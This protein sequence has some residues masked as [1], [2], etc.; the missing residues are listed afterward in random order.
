MLN[1][2]NKERLR[3]FVLKELKENAD[4]FDLESE[5][6]NSLTY[7]ENKNII[8]EKIGLF[9]EKNPLEDVNRDKIKQFER[10]QSNLISSS[11]MDEVLIKN[12]FKDCRIVSLAGLKN[13]GKTNNLVYLIK[14]LRE[15]NK[16]IPIYVF[17]MPIQVMN[18]LTRFNIKEISSLKHLIRKKNCLLII[19][20]FQKL[21]LNDRRYKDDLDDFIDFVYHNNVY[22]L[23]SSPNIREFNSIIGGITEKWL[24]KS[25]R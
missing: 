15:T 10:E 25:V 24:L 3:L 4:L 5:I 21:K 20:E 7:E 8:T 13:T 23:F 17:G 16:D 2:Q 12:L 11:V 18:Y 6:D 19:D 22:V 1:E 14:E 9:K